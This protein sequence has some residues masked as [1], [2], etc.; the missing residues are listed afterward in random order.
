MKKII[1]TITALFL[2]AILYSSCKGHETCPA[3]GKVD[4][5]S[6]ETSA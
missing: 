5:A 1:F 3:Y 6:N 4:S 2:V